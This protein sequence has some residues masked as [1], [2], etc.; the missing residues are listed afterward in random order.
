VAKRGREQRS[1]WDEIAT[2]GV[3]LRGGEGRAY[4]FLLPHGLRLPVLRLRQV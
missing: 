4:A 1:A 3:G 2:L